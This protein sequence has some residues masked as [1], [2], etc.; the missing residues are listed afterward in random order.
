MIT[1][2]RNTRDT[3][4][5][6]AQAR[7]NMVAAWPKSFYRREFI[8]ENILGRRLFVVNAPAGVQRVFVTNAAN[9]RKSPTNTATLKPL[10]GQGL[11]VSEGELWTRQ[12]KVMSPATGPNRLAPYADVIRECGEELLADWE[13]RPGAFEV[14]VNEPFTLCTAEVISRIM[15]GYRLGADGWKLY[16]AFKEYQTSAGRVHVAEILGFP[17]WLPRPGMFAGRRAVAKFDEVLHTIIG[18]A[19]A[20]GQPEREDLIQMLLNY[21]DE[22]GQPM[23]PGLVRDE[24]ASIFLAGHETTA[25]TLAWAFYLLDQHRA[26]EARVHAELD[27]ALAGRPPTIDDLEKLPFCRAVIDETLR[28]FP[29]VHVFSRQALGEDEV[30]GHRIPKGAFI[31]V[32]SWVL[33]R[34]QLWWEEPN[35]FRPERFLPENSAKINRFAYIPF[36]TGPRVCLGKHLGLLEATMLF[37]MIAQR[38]QL[39]LRP[40][41]KVEPLGRMTLRPRWELPMIVTA[42]TA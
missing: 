31:I 1:F 41:H 25:I 23:S 37:A 12:R 19:R 4:R 5:V 33:H 18:A 17:E 39:R 8:V 15:F 21:R 36:G 29:P 42:R 2:L 34:H 9:Y 6:L 3:L 24:V 27:R 10:L 7:D 30:C 20:R 26:A 40:G 28:L 35:E 38:Y 32:S 22:H 14:D 11:F 16:E 13:K